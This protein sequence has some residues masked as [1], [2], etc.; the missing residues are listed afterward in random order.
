M[1]INSAQDAELIIQK[2]PSDMGIH[3]NARKGTLNGP[4][5]ILEGLGFERTVL[6]DEVFPNEFSLDETQHKILQN[7]RELSSY[8]KPIISVGGDHSVTYP[9]VK[10]LK[11]RHPEMKLLWLDAHLDVKRKVGDNVSHD[12]LVR[13]LIEEEIFKPEEIYFIGFT[14]ID[15]DEKK[16]I[17]N[18]EF[19]FYKPDEINRFLEEFDEEAYLS[20]DIDVLS[21]DRIQGTGYPDGQLNTQTVL[22]II[23]EVQ[24]YHGDIVEV[25]PSLDK[26]NTVKTAKEVLQ[27]LVESAKAN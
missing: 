4:S 6:V 24:P 9:V 17:E 5:K 26:G 27:V 3:R 10:V 20:I 21:S 15:K 11:K 22:N 19:N 16:Y 13:Q 18:K 8:G 2:L 12:V 1:R 25:A 14:R 7:T 23:R